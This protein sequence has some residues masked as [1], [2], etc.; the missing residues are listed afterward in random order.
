LCYWVLTATGWV[1][2]RTTVQ[3]VTKEDQL[4]PLVKAKIDN[5]DQKVK[6]KLDDQHHQE[7]IPAEGLTLED[8]NLNDKPEEETKVKQDHYTDKAYNA[9]L[10]AELLVPSGDNYIMGRVTKCIRDSNGN[11]IGHCN[12]N[13]LL[14]T[15]RYEVQFGDGSMLEYAANL[16]AKNMMSQSDAEGQQHMIFKE[17]IDH[18]SGDTTIKNEDGFTVRFNGNVHPKKTTCGWDICVEWRD[19]STSWL[20]LKDVKD[21][22]PLKLAQYAVANQILEEPTFKWWVQEILKKKKMIIA[23][24]KMKY[25]QTTHKFGIKIPKS[26]EQCTLN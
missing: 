25:W 23:K 20:P 18:C 11:P 1:I 12:S 8:K 14:D 5:F 21:A 9:Y 19:G 24:I 3:R 2:A 10:G 13:P 26:V 15:R 4:L 17:I 7:E 16:V 22:N 6:E